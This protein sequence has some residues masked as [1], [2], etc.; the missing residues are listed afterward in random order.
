[1]YRLSCLTIKRDDYVLL[2]RWMPLQG[3]SAPTVTKTK[4]TLQLCRSQAFFL[5][6]ATLYPFVGLSPFCLNAFCI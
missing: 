2:A 6:T 5:L 3:V 1:M 4:Q